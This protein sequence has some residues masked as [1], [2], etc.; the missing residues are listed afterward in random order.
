MSLRNLKLT[1]AYDGSQFF[2]WQIQ[3]KVATVQGTVVD[4]LQRITGERIWLYGASRTDAGV[5]AEGQVANFKTRNPIPTENL[6]RALNNLLPPS[7]RAMKVEEVLLEFHARWHARG[8]TY[9]YR[10]LC[11]DICPPALASFVYH[12]AMPLDDATMAAAAPLFEGEHDFSSF[13][14]WDA[15]E[16]DHSRVRTVSS[17]RLE[18]RGQELVYT[19]RGRSFLRY[20]VRKMVGTLIEVGKGRLKPEDIPRLLEARDR[21]QSGFTAPPEGLWLLEV[22]YPTETVGVPASAQSD[23]DSV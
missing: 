22:E 8:K 12:Y 21:T 15:E 23:A 9:C 5:H 20:Q 7:V 6:R 14:T 4:V 16:A 11:T 2:G 19:V 3:P 10:I 1:L 18:R 17:S 13:G